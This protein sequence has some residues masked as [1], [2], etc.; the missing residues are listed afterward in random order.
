MDDENVYPDHWAHRYGVLTSKY[1]YYNSFC[2]YMTARFNKHHVFHLIDK[3]SPSQ[4]VAGTVISA[5]M[6]KA[7][8]SYFH[9]Y[10]SLKDQLVNFFHS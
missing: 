5:G 7:F 6:I 4:G 1:S 9:I 3:G 2:S 8:K 10:H